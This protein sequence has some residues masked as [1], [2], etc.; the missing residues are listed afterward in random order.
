MSWTCWILL[1]AVFLALYDLAKK[2]SVRDNAVLPVLLCSTLCGCAAFVGALAFG[3]RLG[4]ALAALDGRLVA[5]GLSKAAIVAISWIFTFSA[6]RTLPIT[7]ATPIRA[8]APALV[9]VLALFLYGEV[10]TALQAVGIVTVLAGYWTFSWAGRAEGIDFLRN[11]AVW[12]A[13]AGAVFS[14]LSA[15]WDKYVFQVASAPIE[16]VQLVFQLGLVLVYGLCLGGRAAL[17]RRLSGLPCHAFAFRWT[18][19]LVGVLLAFADWLYFRGVAEPGAPIS[20]ASLMRRLS[21][22]ITFVLGARFF[23]ETNLRR[24]ALALAAIV[25]GIAIL[26]LAKT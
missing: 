1:S 4:A 7:I 25:A 12:C 17:R 18:I 24:K 20:L 26:C 5:L 16:P 3:G 6:L 23:H 14:A 19:P 13:V 11:R 21:V 9:I 2:A 10:P 15:L 22:V 8:S